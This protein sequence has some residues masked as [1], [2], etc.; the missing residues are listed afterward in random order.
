MQF[1]PCCSESL[2]VREIHFT[3]C[4]GEEEKKGE[5]TIKTPA[6]QNVSTAGNSAFAV[7]Y[8]STSSWI[9]WETC[10]ENFTSLKQNVE[11]GGQSC[12]LFF[13]V[14]NSIKDIPSLF[15]KDFKLFCRHAPNNKYINRHHSEK[16]TQ[17]VI[18]IR[19]ESGNALVLNHAR[20]QSQ[21][22]E[23]A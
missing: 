16:S 11:F 8:V 19:L 20:I 18:Q 10:N 14:T 23:T 9:R 22:R 12:F 1:E 3:D 15:L 21:W 6:I 4:G 13:Y 5:T 7:P 17:E 2:K